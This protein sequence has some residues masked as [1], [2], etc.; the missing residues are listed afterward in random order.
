MRVW[1]AVAL[2]VLAGCGGTASRPVRIGSYPI[3]AFFPFYLAQELGHFREAGVDVEIDDFNAGPKLAEALVGGSSDVGTDG[4]LYPVIMA[5]QGRELKTFFTIQ[6]SWTGLLVAAP[7]QKQRIR[8]ARD[9]KNSK[10]GVGSSG[11]LHYRML[12]F[13]LSRE[14]M[15][16]SDVEPIP[17]GTTATAVAAIQY[18][19]VDA[20]IVNGSL[21]PRLK[22]QVPEVQVLIDF[23]APGQSKELFGVN[24]FPG[25]GMFATVDWLAR[26]PIKARGL[27]RAITRTLQW[28]SEHSPEELRARLP[29]KLRSEDAAFDLEELRILIRSLSKDGRMPAGGPEAAQRVVAASLQAAKSIDLAATW[30]NE[31]VEQPR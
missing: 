3:L 16:F 29:E 27:A 31:F 19:K 7:G 2:M 12:G 25:T 13:L 28:V 10:V 9:L 26:N 18:G 14:G 21:L 5:A 11:G 22:R 23:R 24:E 20:A 1:C 8:A 15:A 4:Y 6:T 17:I 30:T